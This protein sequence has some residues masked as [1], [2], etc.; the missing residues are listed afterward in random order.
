MT[1]LTSIVVNSADVQNL[2]VYQIC[3]FFAALHIRYL[4]FKFCSLVDHINV[5]I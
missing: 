2:K 3:H 4:E 5:Y 1:N